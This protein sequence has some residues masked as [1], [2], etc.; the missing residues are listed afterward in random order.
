VTTW[1]EAE[2][3]AQAALEE[4]A[5]AVD[6][7]R[8]E[9]AP[10]VSLIVVDHFDLSMVECH[11]RGA[12]LLVRSV[13]RLEAL[14]L[15]RESRSRVAVIAMNERGQGLLERELQLEPAWR[16]K[17]SHGTRLLVVS[18]VRWNDI[19]WYLVEYESDEDGCLP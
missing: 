13:S 15:V 18:P 10:A 16:P 11:P 9:A 2:V 1:D 7:P 3:H 17:V 14:A 12:R 8:P 4:L 19:R 5:Q 6:E